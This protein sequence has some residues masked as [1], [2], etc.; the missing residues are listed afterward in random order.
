[1]TRATRSDRP[2][3]ESLFQAAAQLERAIDAASPNADWFASARAAIRTC[4]LAVEKHLANAVAMGTTLNESEPRLLPSLEKL[5]AALAGLLVE[6]W[7]MKG[8]IPS[9]LAP[10]FVSRLRELL[11]DVR[12]LASEEFDLAWEMFNPPGGHE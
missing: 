2:V 9:Q 4:T 8:E 6:L 10:S 5:E 11:R 3:Q 12:H 1:M 7:E